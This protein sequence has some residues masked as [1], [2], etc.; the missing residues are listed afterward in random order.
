MRH[1]IQRYA[2]VALLSVTFTADAF[3]QTQAIK[4]ETFLKAQTSWDGTPIVYP[5]GKP[6]I[7]GMMIEIAP[8]AETGWHSHPVSSFGMLLQG[9]LEVVLK[10]GQKKRMKTGDSLVEVSNTLHNGKN[11]G[12]VPVKI[13]VFYAGQAEQ[14]LTVKETNQ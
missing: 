13:I 4:A 3:E 2:F 11:V 9:E 7:T 10:N 8:G 1:F 14:A 5:T 6:E 12:N